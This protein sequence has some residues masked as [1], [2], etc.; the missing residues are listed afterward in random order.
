MVELLTMEP[1]QDPVGVTRN[2]DLQDNNGQTALHIATEQGQ[3]AIVLELL[4][5]GAN[6]NISDN[7]GKLPLQIA[8]RGDTALVRILLEGGAD[9]Y[10]GTST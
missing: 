6:P 2:I 5:V 8:T 9:T 3:V 7:S 1:L 4:K 10:L